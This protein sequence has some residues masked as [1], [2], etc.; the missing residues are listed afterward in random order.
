M[1]HKLQEFVPN[2]ILYLNVESAPNPAPKKLKILTLNC[3][4]TVREAC[5]IAQ[6]K[7]KITILI[8]YNNINTC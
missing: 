6:R 8:R 3:T 1:T 2:L 5:P 4:M 7:K